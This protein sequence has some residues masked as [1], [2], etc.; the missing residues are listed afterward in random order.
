MRIRA[1]HRAPPKVEGYVIADHVFPRGQ[2]RWCTQRR[3]RIYSW[4]DTLFIDVPPT[5]GNFVCETKWL[6]GTCHRSFM[7]H[8]A[9]PVRRSSR[10]DRDVPRIRRD[11]PTCG[12]CVL[13][14]RETYRSRSCREK[15]R[16]YI[17]ARRLEFPNIIPILSPR[18]WGAKLEEFVNSSNEKM[19][20]YIFYIRM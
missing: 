20:K 13:A 6:R 3:A 5:G 18:N 1:H 15:L 12:H 17:E 8:R 16:K 7:T 2:F 14:M 4:P 10:R 11:P 19:R 9:E